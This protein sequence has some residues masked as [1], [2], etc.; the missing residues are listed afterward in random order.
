MINRIHK[1]GLRPLREQLIR[2]SAAEVKD[3][4]NAITRG[5]VKKHVCASHGKTVK[6]KRKCAIQKKSSKNGVNIGLVKH[7][8]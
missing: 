4:C 7:K 5:C 8:D 3:R 6:R 1:K 2:G